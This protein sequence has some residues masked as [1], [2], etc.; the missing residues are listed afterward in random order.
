MPRG[1]T[2]TGSTQW[3]HQCRGYRNSGDDISLALGAESKNTGCTTEGGYE[4]I[5]NSRRS[6][7]KKLRLCLTQRG[8]KEIHHRREHTYECCH[9][10]ILHCTAH[11]VEVIDT[12]SQS[13]T[14]D[15]THKRRYEHRSDNYRSGVDIQPK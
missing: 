15:R 4:H 14:D 13:H 6:A 3:R 10:E 8:D 7:G 11:K 2:I 1:K 5:V 9:T 12:H